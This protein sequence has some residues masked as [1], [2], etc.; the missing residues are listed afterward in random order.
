MKA[1]GEWKQVKADI[2][3]G[4]IAPSDQVVQ[5]YENDGVFLD[6]LAGF[7]GGGI[8]SN[9]CVIVIASSNHLE[10]LHLR[11]ASYGINIQSLIDEER[12]IPVD[13]EKVLDTFMVDGW[14]DE[15]LF[16][17]AI[18]YFIEKGT[19]KGRRIRSFGEM[20]AIFWGKGLNGATVQLEHLWNKFCKDRE[21]SLFCAY[22]KIGFTEDI[23]DSMKNI[24]DCHSKIIN[25]TEK[26]LT[27][28]FYTDVKTKKAS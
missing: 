24:C 4:E 20:V 26:Q 21:L 10:A 3:W 14:P 28:I 16:N 7:V 11:L 12:Y 6:T 2:V 25:G 27:E 1:S 9:E 19:C 8:N 22:P 17:N 5:I 18:T 15:N 23:N 13:A